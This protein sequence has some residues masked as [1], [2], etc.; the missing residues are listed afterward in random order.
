[1][2]APTDAECPA[3]GYKELFSN[4]DIRPR[5]MLVLSDAESHAMGY[6]TI[7]TGMLV[8]D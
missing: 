8:S 7:P 2:T 5:R 6:R 4:S 3:I 1:M